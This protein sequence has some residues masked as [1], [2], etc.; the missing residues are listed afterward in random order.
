VPSRPRILK[1]NSRPDTQYWVYTTPK[2]SKL[3][4]EATKDEVYEWAKEFFADLPLESSGELGLLSVKA[5]VI[6]LC[7]EVAMYKYSGLLKEQKS[8][9]AETEWTTIGDAF[10]K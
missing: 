5:E 9:K 10:K 8:L 4:K 2:R 6:D 7:L 1:K 3:Y